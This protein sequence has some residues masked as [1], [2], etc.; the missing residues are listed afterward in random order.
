MKIMLPRPTKKRYLCPTLHLDYSKY[1]QPSVGICIAKYFYF[2][3][4]RLTVK[5]YK[6][7]IT[8]STH[9]VLKGSK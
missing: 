9:T 5:L 7:D 4:F 1:S 8:L 6:L 2:W 3:G